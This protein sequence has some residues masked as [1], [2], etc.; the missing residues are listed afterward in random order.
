MTKTNEIQWTELLRE[1]VTKPGTILAAYSN[2]HN[3]SLGNCIL[4]Y[5]QCEERGLPFGPIATYKRWQE[6]DRQVKKGE[7]ALTLCMPITKKTKKDVEKTEA[8]SECGEKD[9]YTFFVYRNRWF[10]LSQT[11]GNDI[12]APAISG[13]EKEKAL[14]ELG[15]EQE[16]FAHPNGN[17]QGYSSPGGKISINPVAQLPQKTLFHELAHQVLGH[18]GDETH[19]DGQELSKNL[20]EAE[21]EAVALICCES[22]R[23]EG[24]EY[25]R[26]YIQ[27]WLSGEEIPERSAQRIFSAAD[28]ILRAGERSNPCNQVESSG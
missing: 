21:A 13:W 11:E 23:H 17:T 7:R 3:F 27:H 5:L 24:A 26:G 22:L 18:V 20:R 2:F 15:I 8:T 6:L 9:S 14:A 25:C 16:P 12:E 1:A 10:V 4:A 28:K 19:V